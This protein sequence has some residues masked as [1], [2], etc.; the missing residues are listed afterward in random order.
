M[1]FLTGLSW[2]AD[3]PT[4]PMEWMAPFGPGGPSAIA[5]KIIGDATSKTL[6]KPVL[7]V[8][9]PGGGG[10][11]GGA[12]VAKAKPD[13]YTLL[14]AN[15]ATNGISL[16]IKK[17]V[18]YKNSDFEFLA[19]FGALDLG[20]LVKGDS[21]FRRSM[22]MSILRRRIPSGSNRPP[23]DREREDIFAWNCLN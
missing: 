13:G 5:L 11:I 8:P 9:A 17:E 16:Y 7:I 12:R 10:M 22:S 18:P 2:A 1:L 21:P 4:K 23:P 6:G 15:S 14:N 19:E 20:L 3:F